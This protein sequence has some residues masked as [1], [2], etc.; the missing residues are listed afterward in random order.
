MEKRTLKQVLTV[1][2]TAGCL[3]GG[4]MGASA[5]DTWAVL[6]NYT[7]AKTEAPVVEV[8]SSHLFTVPAKDLVKVDKV[9]EL[10]FLAPDGSETPAIPMGNEAFHAKHVLGTLGTYV[11]VV[12]SPPGFSSKTTD[13]YKQGKTKKDL[14]NVVSCSYS[15]KFS[16][17]LFDVG[18]PGGAVFSRMF[19]H[20]LEIIPL[21]DPSGMKK[22]EILS[23]KVLFQGKPFRTTVSGTYA[24]FSDDPGT[25]AYTTSTNKDGIA[26]I[27]LI[28]NG[29]WLLLVKEK[30]DYPDKTVCDAKSYSAALTFH[31]K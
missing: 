30:A 8:V 6:K 17:A 20:S 5:H 27:R 2:A 4:A 1:A 26:K 12:I 13:G 28:H 25:F 18:H 29:A 15:E 21:Q 7:P 31:I 24:G 23:I 11:A 10:F 3:L 16:K 9:K 22:G 14:N 19:G